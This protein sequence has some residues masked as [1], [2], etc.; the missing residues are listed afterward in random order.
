MGLFSSHEIDP[1][2]IVDKYGGILLPDETVLTAFQSI[3][4][5]AVLTTHRF[6]LVDVQGLTGS[7]VSVQNVPY[8]SIVRFAVESAGTFD[9]DS[10]LK[11]WVVGATSPLSVSISRKADPQAILRLL[12]EHTL[13]R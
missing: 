13:K 6:I 7:K 4:D 9:L 3:R 10:D 2:E 11:I 12:A 8:H 1:Q 5:T